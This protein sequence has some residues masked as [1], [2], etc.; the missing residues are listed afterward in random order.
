MA[1]PQLYDFETDPLQSQLAT[2]RALRKKGM[3][4]GGSFTPGG[5]Y[6]GNAGSQF[7][8]ALAG[9]AMEDT[10]Q[11]GLGDIQR[12]R[13]AEFASTMS[14]IPKVNQQLPMQGPTEDG[15][16]LSGSFSQAKSPDQ[17]NTEMQGFGTKLMQSRD[18]RAQSLA[19]HVLQKSLDQPYKD[20]ERDRDEQEA[21]AFLRD[22]AKRTTPATE[23]T[24]QETPEPATGD[25]SQFKGDIR[26]LR[27]DILAI[28]DP[29]EREKAMTVFE[30]QVAAAAPKPVP[31]LPSTVAAARKSTAKFAASLAAQEARADKKDVTV[32]ITQPFQEQQQQKRLNATAE[33]TDKKLAAKVST[34]Y[35]D[36][37]KTGEEYLAS[38][39]PDK[40]EIVKG[41]VNYTIDPKSLST[42]TGGRESAIAAAKLVDPNFNNMKYGIRYGV[43]QEFTKGKTAD[44]IVAL[45]QAINHMGTLGELAKALNNGD[46][47]PVNYITTLAKSLF[48]QNA[49]TDAALASQAV[50]EELMRVFRQVGASEREAADWEAKMKAGIKSPQQMVGAITTASELLNGRIKALNNKWNNGMEV[51]TG[52]PNM[53]SDEARAVLAAYPPA[54]HK[55][56]PASPLQGSVAAAKDTPKAGWTQEMWDTLSDA[57]KA[58]LKGKS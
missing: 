5:I 49:P 17:Y 57:E 11:R 58:K 38:L 56:A 54:T 23:L 44:N 28:P 13:D 34:P 46:I 15:D 22:Q 6:V 53:L 10:A 24:G 50:G 12:Q 35:G 41:L 33:E 37:T 40:Q 1:Q 31:V 21:Q 9:S 20:I 16:V 52:Y 45:D 3:D 4:E 48:G 36:L 8:N 55:P 14:Q 18:P 25:Y 29:V 42:R 19:G 7:M 2:A 32:N 51:K 26:Q 27:K 39:P 47:T 43:V 30:Q